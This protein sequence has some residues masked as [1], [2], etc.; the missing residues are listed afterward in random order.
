MPVRIKNAA[1]K[2]QNAVAF[3]RYR[4]I[5][6]IWICH[7][8]RS[9]LKMIPK[10]CKMKTEP[11]AVGVRNT[12]SGI[13]TSRF[14]D[15][16]PYLKTIIT[17]TAFCV[18]FSFPYLKGLR[19]KWTLGNLLKHFNGRASCE[20]TKTLPFFF[21]PCPAALC[22]R[23]LK[24]YHDLCPPFV[25]LCIVRLFLTQARVISPISWYDSYSNR[26]RIV[27]LSHAVVVLL[28]QSRGGVGDDVSPLFR[29]VY[30]QTL[31]TSVSVPD[32][33]RRYS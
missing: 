14:S 23:S 31:V 20:H 30:R 15:Q 32:L 25:K 13:F 5:K 29:C 1:E 24:L 27:H 9:V 11:L 3:S 22:E 7:F 8:N 28:W 4:G 26:A 12:K 19:F 10:W 6:I 2:L 18:I 17:L 16:P 33:S 21:F